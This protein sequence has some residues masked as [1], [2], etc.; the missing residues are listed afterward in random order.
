MKF[1]GIIPA[2]YASTRF[3]GKPL[4]DILGQPMIQR[5]YERASQVLDTVVVATDN[6]RIY[7]AVVQFGGRVVMTSENHKTGTDR[8]YEAL[9]KLPE[10]YDVVINIQGDEP[11]IAIDQ[12]EALKNC[13]V[14]DQIQLA[15]LVKPFDANTSIDEL[16]NPNTPKV[17]LSQAGEAI[18]FSRSVIPYLRGVEKSQWAAAHTY[19]KHIGIYAYRTD[20]L[21]QI[22]KMTQTPIEKA[23]SLEQLRWLEN[24][25]HIH[26]AITHS[27]NHSIDTPEDLQ[28]VVELMK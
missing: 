22:T 6:Q 28:R 26:V 25:L 24:G 19:Y 2:R 1:V 8:C 7:D 13:F 23:E 5:V 14:S 21:A 3:P 11:F 12:I 16:E 10:T 9:T 20:I 27:D 4:A 17:I 15:T 18:C